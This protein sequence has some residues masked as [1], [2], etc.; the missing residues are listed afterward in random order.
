[1]AGSISEVK[2]GCV[3]KHQGD[4]FLVTDSRFTNP[5]KGSPFVTAKMKSITKGKSIEMTY[6]P[7]DDIEI[8]EVQNQRLQYLYKNGG[9]YSFMNNDNYE[10]YELEEEIVG[11]AGKYLKD[12]MEVYGVMYEDR[13]IAIS[14]APKMQYKVV[15]APPAVKGDTASSGRLLKE[16]TLENGLIVKAP[17][18]IKTGETILINTD[19]GEYCERINE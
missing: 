17:I 19:T 11:D 15:D 16:V 1:M 4:L 18:F 10:T 6:K 14:I 5:G 9:F 7:V 12:G 3:I 8:V 2:K 13:V